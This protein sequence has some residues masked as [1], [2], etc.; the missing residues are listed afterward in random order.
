ML[1]TV[2]ILIFILSGSLF[3]YFRSLLKESILLQQYRFVTELATHLDGNIKLAEEQLRLAAASINSKNIKNQQEL[4]NILIQKNALRYIFDAGFLV[5]GTDGRVLTE[6]VDNPKL[7][8]QDLGYRDYVKECLRTGKTLMS[9]PI[10]PKTRP[11]KPMIAMVTPIHDDA[12]GI[13]G[14]F[15]GYFALGHDNFLTE[16]SSSSLEKGYL[17]IL[18]S[19]IIVMHDDPSRVMEVVA[20]GQNHGI[21][22]VEK[23]FEGSLEIVNSKGINLLSSFKRVGNTR[24]ILAGN[25][26]ADVAFS[27]LKRLAYISVV[28][29]LIGIFVSM[30]LVWYVIHRLTRP[31]QYLTNHLN[32]TV[33]DNT[34]WTP[35]ELVTG[36]ELEHLA[37]AYNSMMQQVHEAQRDLI[38][39]KDF[40]NGII[41]NAAAPMFVL[42]PD[43]TI[44]SWNNA[45]AKL[46][47]LNSS[48]MKGTKNQWIPFYSQMRPVLADLMI[49][50]TVEKVTELYTRFESSPLV[51]GAVR[52]EGWF[53][54][55]GG[56]RRYLF[57]EAA[58]VF[59]SDNELVAVVETLEDITERKL[60]QE[61]ISTQNQF[62][63][64][65]MDAI[66]SPV[67]YKDTLGV[68]I[69]CNK[70][71]L[72]FFGKSST[73]LLG[74]TIFE[75]TSPEYAA[76]STVRDKAILESGKNLTYE[77][78]LVRA[79]GA[80]RT[81]FMTKAPFSTID[82]GPGGIVGAFVDL[83]EQYRMDEQVRK[84]SQTMEQSPVSIVITGLDGT[85][86]Y[87]NPRFCQTTG[88]S[89]EEAIGLNPRVLKSGSMAHEEYV[90]L[91][92]TISS[93][94]EWRGDLHNKRKDG[95]LYW[96]YAS[97][98][99]ILDKVG[100]V[101][102]YLAVKEDITARKAVESEL[103]NSRKALE[104]QHHELGQLFELVAMGKREWE[105][106]LDHLRD[107]VILTDTEH[108]IRRCN[109]LLADISGRHVNEL[110]GEDWR[111]VIA[112]NGFAFVKLDSSDGEVVHQPSG[113]SY[114]VCI[115]PITD[116]ERITGHVVSLND[117]TDLRAATQE[118][119]KAY[120]ELKEAQLQVFQQE[121]MASIG[122]L[123]AGVAHE[124]NNPMGFISSNLATLH[125]Y[126]DRVVEYIGFI[127]QML[128]SC[129][130]CNAAEQ[131]QQTRK[132]LKVD[133]IM[134]DAHQLIA[135]SQDGAGRVRRIVQD[136]KSFSRVDQ[137]ECAL[138][139]MNEALEI[140]INIA[141]NEIKYVADLQREFGELPQI[142]CYPQ[143]LNQV[144]LNLLIN[145]A[146]AME[147]TH[148]T[149]TV[150]TWSEDQNVFVSVADTG[151]GIP[152][153]ILQRI[154][155]PFFTTK[156]VGKGT[157]LGLSI[158]YD[159]IK[160]HNGEITVKSQVGVGSTFTVMLPM[161]GP[162]ME[163]SLKGPSLP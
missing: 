144:F 130:D 75:I 159:I 20:K 124:I 28:L 143:Q 25:T 38:R 126:L 36:D 125:K 161:D 14:L 111:K 24:W 8:G 43:H 48:Q 149:I 150:R 160:K 100:K 52:V 51:Q 44:I 139:N 123:A 138:I 33:H 96:E 55:I 162:P 152:E 17:Y 116:N 97:I 40:Y 163:K 16:L 156:V 74:R 77:T 148:G 87:V 45:M 81:V 65:I 102:G 122:Q 18:D 31:I 46:T 64:E 54:A 86:E 10:R 22:L 85:I 145:A 92:N 60:A 128:A 108:H 57:F 110:V 101:T 136:L 154:F 32:Q 6:S 155:E 11:Q 23:G 61:A 137:A 112:E 89:Q 119:E 107:I 113:R 104:A 151:K 134:G 68:Y 106:T 7:V 63:Q 114:D 9:Q 42:A 115:Y 129:S 53:E 58:K 49:D 82:G 72:E 62:L 118:L 142:K 79:D 133:Y 132:R 66:P 147:D 71:F 67:F 1:A 37:Q 157:G 69:G 13:I 50:N 4:N 99:P 21:D 93:G 59:N 5:I 131:L 94:K 2:A 30:I 83:T 120:L 3:F 88:Y 39:E 73:E 34:A 153:E 84:M 12:G 78:T 135:E 90:N 35:I 19:R 56:K 121:K 15:A 95:T 70:A 76:D 91:W 105:E 29:T 140:T 117:T 103:A 41:E 27:P 146:H 141:W 127:D 26:P 109:K 80:T 158:S 47:G 98:S